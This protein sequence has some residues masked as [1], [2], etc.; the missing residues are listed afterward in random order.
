MMMMTL[1][2][3]V[4]VM[5]LTL[6]APSLGLEIESLAVP[7]L[8]VAGDSAVMACYYSVPDTRLPELDIKWY[9]GARPEPFMV[10]GVRVVG[11]VLGVCLALNQWSSSEL[12]VLLL[13]S[14]L[15]VLL[16]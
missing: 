16:R 9:H 3:L 12:A 11:R 2:T 14:V 4:M 13:S 15:T 6:T 1:L 5:M 8:V 7:E 10:S